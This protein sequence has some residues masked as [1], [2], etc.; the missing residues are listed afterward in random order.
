MNLCS[1]APNHAWLS[2]GPLLGGLPLNLSFS[3][4]SAT[5]PLFAYLDEIVGKP[6]GNVKSENST[7]IIGEMQIKYL[8]FK[9][10]GGYACDQADVSGVPSL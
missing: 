4:G 5:V 2:S 7:Q 3:V 10:E 8:R 1:S 6:I 9:A